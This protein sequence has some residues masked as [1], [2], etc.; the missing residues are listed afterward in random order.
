MF[1][2]WEGSRKRGAWEDSICVR[3][4]PSCGSKKFTVHGTEGV[5]GLWVWGN[6]GREDWVGGNAGC[7]GQVENAFVSIPLPLISK[8]LPRQRLPMTEQH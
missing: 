5:H 1:A 6:E 3:K 4:T 8:L 7:E 2:R